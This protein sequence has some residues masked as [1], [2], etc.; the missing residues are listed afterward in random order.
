LQAKIEEKLDIGG[1]LARMNA[2]ENI[3]E[4]GFS[5]QTFKTSRTANLE[6]IPLPSLE[7]KPVTLSNLDKEVLC[8][9]SLIINQKER[10]E[11][12]I[13]KLY[14]LRQKFLGGDGEKITTF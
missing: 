12:W 11:Q 8:H 5:P 10:E 4:E 13:K 1:Q 6:D 3:E 2:I 9:P 7:L 14:T